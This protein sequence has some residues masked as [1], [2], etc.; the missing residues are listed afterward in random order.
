MSRGKTRRD[1]VTGLVSSEVPLYYQLSTILREQIRSGDYRT[2]DQLPTEADLG[3]EFGVSRITVRQAL[4]SLEEKQL[5]R[6]EAGRGTFVTAHAT[7]PDVIEMSGSLD[8]LISMGQ[9][10]SVKLIDLREVTATHQDAEVF[11]FEEG[12]PVMQCTRVRFNH[13]E[14]YS[15]IIDRLPKIIA[16]RF[17]DHDWETGAIL[18]SLERLGLRPGDADQNVSA[19]VAN[20]SLA[21]LLNTQIGAPLLSI[22]RVIHTDKGQAVD[23]VQTYYRSDIYSLKMHLT[24]NPKKVPDVTAWTLKGAGDSP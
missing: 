21:K 5:I 10:T 3:T 6:R 19:T 9:G 14:P 15:Y 16:D 12:S 13:D 8:D 7:V 4:R 23:R 24:R 1:Q 2:G 18:E 22:D 20:T 17:E 11:E